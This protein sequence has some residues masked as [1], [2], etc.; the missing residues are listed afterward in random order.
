MQNQQMAQMQAQMN[1]NGSVNGTPVMGNMAQ[2]KRM[3]NNDPVEK[4]N[5]YIY[6]YFLRNRHHAL[7]RA[8]LDGDLKMSTEKPSPNKSNVASDIDMPDDMPLPALPAGQVADN[9]FLLDWWVQFWDIFAAAR[10]PN[11]GPKN[12]VQY[13]GHNRNLGQMQNE[14]RNQRLMM[15]NNPMANAQYM[16]ARNGGM[17]NGKPTELQRTAHMNNRPT[18]NPMAGMQSMKNPNMIQMQRDGSNMDMNGNRPNSPGSNEN[19]PSPNKRPRVEGGM[20]AGNMPNNQFNE[21]MPQGPGAQQKNIE[22]I[23][24]GVQG[25]PM[26]QSGLDGQDLTFAGNGPRPGSM[27]TNPPGAPQQGNHALQDYQ[28]QLML[29]EQQNKKRLLMARQEQDNQSGHPQQG[30]IGAP[31][32]GAAMS[33]QGSRA[34]GPSPNPA[35]QMKRGTPKLGQQNLPGSPM[36]EGI[37][38]Q[39]RG[40]PAPNM[41]FDPTLAPPGMPPQFYPQNMGP[42]PNGNPMMRPPS[43]HPNGGPQFNGQPMTQ[44]QMQAMRNGQMA[45]NGGWRGGP[46]P[47]M[48][49]PGGQQMGGPMGQNPQ[50][51]QQMPPPPAPTN[52]QP[53]PEPSPSVS[54]QAPPTPNQGNKA[55]PKKKVTKD[56]KPANKKGNAGATPATSNGEEPPTPTSS[57][58]V[59]PITPVHKQSFNQGQNGGPQ[60]PVQPQPPSDQPMDNGGPPFGNIDGDPNGIDLAFNFGDDAGALE[61][62]DF[63]SFLHTG[64]DND[65]FGNLVSDFDF[66][67]AVDA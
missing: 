24:S 30:V 25:S 60:Q 6:D 1:A 11:G 29:L 23:N 63:D 18:G 58:P 5:T 43:S 21:F 10:G 14:Q 46:Q 40:S 20:N 53:R 31:G 2:P 67:N 48:M 35:D 49:G 56:N 26:A 42:G 52:E 17:T 45:Q 3:G 8:M 47:G 36:P 50:Q 44:E 55:N 27:P 34:G 7:A 28:M 57:T 62:F 54:N 16:M 64:N 61:N 19:A 38:G 13:L 4:L 39:Q 9:S 22:G 41:N 51:R 65:A 15:A 32:F 33:P 37:M 66:P 12:A 59:A